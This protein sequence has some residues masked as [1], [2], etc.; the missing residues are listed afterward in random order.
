MYK[1]TENE[2]VG[3]VPTEE[4]NGIL[5]SDGE[6]RVTPAKK[7]KINDEE[8][9]KEEVKAVEANCMFENL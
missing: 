4:D 3:V 6:D 2:I 9:D 1:V 5:D 7:R 8:L